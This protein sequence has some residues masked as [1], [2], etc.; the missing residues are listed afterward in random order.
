MRT[1]CWFFNLNR[2]VLLEGLD[3]YG[4]ILLKCILKKRRGRV[5]TWLMCFKRVSN[6]GL[7]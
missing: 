6:T 7:L 5:L 3:V 2:L 1:T 4:R